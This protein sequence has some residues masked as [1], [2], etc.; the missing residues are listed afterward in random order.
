MQLFRLLMIL[1]TVMI[2][3]YTASVIATYGL[4]LFTP[5]FGQMTDWTWTGQF[6][7]DFQTFLILSGLWTAWRMKFSGKGIVLG[8]VA[9]VFGIL[10][11]APYLLYLTYQ[12]DGNWSKILLGNQG[13]H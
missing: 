9:V 5:F 13:I 2:S 11:T 6:L 3:V 4:D 12:Y 8:I 10:F 1:F 7:F